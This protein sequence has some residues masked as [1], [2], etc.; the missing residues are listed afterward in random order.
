MSLQRSLFWAHLCAG[1]VIGVVVLVMC[2]TGIGLTF[3]RQ[4]DQMGDR[5]SRVAVSP[6][7][8][9]LRVN[10]VM[11]RLDDHVISLDVVRFS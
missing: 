2:V 4:I 10:S 3:E 9:R 11:E 6:G 7:P 5:Q 8:T 1:A